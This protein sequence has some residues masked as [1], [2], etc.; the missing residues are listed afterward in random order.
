MIKNNNTSIISSNHNKLLS[1]SSLFNNDIIIE[2]KSTCGF[3]IL[4]IFIN[5]SRVKFKNES[6]TFHSFLSALLSQCTSVGNRFRNIIH[7]SS[8]HQSWKKLRYC[9][10]HKIRKKNTQCC[11]LYSYFRL[12]LLME[13]DCSKM[14]HLE[15]K[16]NIQ[17]LLLLI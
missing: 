12:A 8:T 7:K 4:I 10:E 15:K 16:L 1:L 6:T 11:N 3:L 5:I 14:R 2:L 17:N 9:R 13:S